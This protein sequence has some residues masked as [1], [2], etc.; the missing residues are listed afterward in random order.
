MQVLSQASI[1]LVEAVTGHG[2]VVKVTCPEFGGLGPVGDAIK[3]PG[4]SQRAGGGADNESAGH[5]SQGVKDRG[6]G[7][8]S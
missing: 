4:V 8:P 2:A 3:A 5:E 6:R 1:G 7:C